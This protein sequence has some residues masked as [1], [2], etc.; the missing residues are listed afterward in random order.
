MAA[1]RSRLVDRIIASSSLIG[2][3]P[4][5]DSCRCIPEVNVGLTRVHV[6]DKKAKKKKKKGL[7]HISRLD[8]VGPA[9]CSRY[10]VLCTQVNMS[11][12]GQIFAYIDLLLSLNS[13]PFPLFSKND[14]R[15]RR[16][17]AGKDSTCCGQGVNVSTAWQ[18]QEE[19]NKLL[20]IFARTRR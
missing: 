19:R 1:R 5:P 11:A 3:F 9:S 12:A 14:P 4:T 6:T 7:L 18:S 16:C 13:P 10:N 15:D 20:R 2:E 17:V 8:A